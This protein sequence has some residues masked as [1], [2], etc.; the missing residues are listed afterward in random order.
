VSPQPPRQEP[1]ERIRRI[2][3][4]SRVPHWVEDCTR[5]G[6][7]FVRPAAKGCRVPWKYFHR[8]CKHHLG[9]LE[10][11]Q[12]RVGECMIEELTDK[13]R[14]LQIKAD[15][16]P[17]D[18][19]AMQKALRKM[20]G[21]RNG[22]EI[23]PEF[24]LWSRR[25]DALA[26]RLYNSGPPIVAYEIKVSRGDWLA[27]LKQPDKRVEAEEVAAECRIAA[28]AGLIPPEELPQGWGLL[29]VRLGP[30]GGV[31][32]ELLLEGSQRPVTSLQT[33]FVARM[34]W[35]MRSR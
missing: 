16:L 21:E 7:P 24:Q 19:H 2:M 25:V 5:C 11:C 6:A 22:W 18:A 28:P 14:R 31:L 10:P 34:L 17:I 26:V 27:E 35:R 15:A 4:H 3:E 32:P 13:A 23:F 29:E 30:R 20:H 12:L 1:L 33:Q 9:G 8:C